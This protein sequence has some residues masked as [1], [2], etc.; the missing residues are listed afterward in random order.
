MKTI[1]HLGPCIVW[2]QCLA[3]RFYHQRKRSVAITLQD[4]W[5]KAHDVFLSE[6]RVYADIGKFIMD[7][8]T[9]TLFY[10]NGRCVTTQD[11]NV[12]VKDKN[13]DKAAVTQF[14][15]GKY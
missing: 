14:V 1:S 2:T 15:R 3:T 8:V 10:T 7:A 4:E 5:I 12:N 11:L 13:Y 9:G 6:G